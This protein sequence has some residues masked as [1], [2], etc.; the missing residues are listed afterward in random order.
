MATSRGISRVAGQMLSSNLLRDGVD[1]AI[2]TDLLYVDV[3]NGKIG[4]RNAA[5]AADLHVN[6][7]ILSD[8]LE[9]SVVN[10]T[11]SV[12]VANTVHATS[13][14]GRVAATMSVEPPSEP[15]S[16]MLWWDT[17]RNLLS[18]Y[19]SLHEAWKTAGL[20]I[21]RYEFTDSIVWNV[22]H[23]MGTTRFRE[24][25]T[26]ADGERFYAKINI[27]NGNR[28]EVVL[29]EATSGFVDVIFD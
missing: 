5:P 27:I 25:L 26:N 24:T 12:V 3:V 6:G 16:G 13:F 18:V 7:S 11:D 2:D 9:T 15:A 21:E 22:A 10:V 19:N 8:T 1:L 14:V 20:K 28:F 23:N 29:S 4:V 17:E